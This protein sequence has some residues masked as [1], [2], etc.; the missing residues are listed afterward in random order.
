MNDNEIENLKAELEHEKTYRESA[1]WQNSEL[2]KQIVTVQEELRR[3]D[4][5]W[6]SDN[7]LKKE[8]ERHR[9]LLDDNDALR[10]QLPALKEQIRSAKICGPAL[11]D[12]VAHV[13]EVESD[14]HEHQPLRIQMVT[15]QEENNKK[16]FRRQC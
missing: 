4:Y 10:N 1:S 13:I 7:E 2:E 8:A 12:V 14:R 3:A 6:S 15:G 11:K 16:T 9:Q 5:P